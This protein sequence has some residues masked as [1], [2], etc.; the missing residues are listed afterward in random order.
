MVENK[1][2]TNRNLHNTILVTRTLDKA[3][4]VKRRRQFKTNIEIETSQG[5][6]LD[7]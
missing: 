6:L 1:N 4:S 7:I 3:R 2:K 5:R